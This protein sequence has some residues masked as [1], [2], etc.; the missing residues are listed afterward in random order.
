MA[1]DPLKTPEVKELQQETQQLAAIAN[2]YKVTTAEHYATGAEHLKRVKGNLSRLE[3]IR[4]GMTQPLDAA[5]RA[6]MDFF[7]PFEE[8]LTRAEGSIKRA[9]IAY[10]EEQLRIQR[11]EQAKVEAAARAERERNER[12]AADARRKAEEDA[13]Q[14]RRDA[15]AAAAAG[16]TAEAA[17][18]AARAEQKVE[19]AEVKAE[20]LEMQ[21]RT[22]V[23]PIIQRETPKVSG[24]S[25]R[26]SSSSTTSPAAAAAA[27]PSSWRSA[28]RP[29]S[30]STTT[31]RR[32][33]CTR[34]TTRARALLRGRVEGRPA[35]RRGGRPVGLAWFSPDCKHFSKAKGGKPVEKKIRGLA[36]VAVRWAKACARA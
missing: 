27:A 8:Q 19:R 12:A 36:W 33:P 18:L 21:A 1:S 22:V 25:D 7:R 20:G 14:L 16:R 9:L 31:P 4:K 34:R 35:R 17:K 30:R 11:A 3:K 28:A 13:A 6:I 5:K 15:E 23:A 24:L 10:N 26:P 32:S 2:D 29:T